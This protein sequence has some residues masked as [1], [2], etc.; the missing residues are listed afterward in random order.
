M[1]TKKLIAVVVT[2]LCFVCVLSLS[3]AASAEDL[4]EGIF[5]YTVANNKATLTKIDYKGLDE[6][7]IPEMLGGYEVTGLAAK[8]MEDEANL[9]GDDTVTAV[10]IPK[11]VTNISSEAFYLADLGYIVV[12]EDNP[13]YSSDDNGVLFNKDKTK[14]LNACICFSGGTYT[15]P[16]G[17]TSIYYRA[18]VH[19][20]FVK[21]IVLPDTV[22][23]I[24]SQAFFDC[25]S[26]ESVNVPEGVTTIY[27]MC[28]AACPS[29]KDVSLPSTLT[30]IKESAFTECY[31][32]E[33]IVIPE[34]VTFLGTYAFENDTS[35]KYVYLPSTLTEIQSG[36]LGNIPAT[37]ICYGGSEEDW[38]KISID[39][40]IYYEGRP[41][42]IDTA[43]IHYN[44]V[45]EAYQ[46][47][48]FESQND[49]LSVYGTGATPSSGETQFHYWDKFSQD[50][51][52][53]IITGQISKIGAHSFENFASLAT[54]IIETNNI[55][56]EPAAFVNCP[57]LENIIIFGNSSFESESF[58]ACAD[59][60]RVYENS[61][62]THDFSLSGTAINVVP[63]TYDGHVLSFANSVKLSSYEFFDTLAAFCLEYDNIEKV[64]FENLT[65]EDIEMYYIPEGG[66]SLKTLDGNTLKNGEIYPTTSTSA[67]GAITFN[68]LVNGM[69]D[70][71]ITHFY[72]IATDE[73]HS[74]IN[75]TEVKIS[76]TVREIMGRALRWIVTLLNKLFTLISRLRK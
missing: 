42:V 71:S 22:T 27:G 21:N 17:V 2:L 18:F 73:N 14:L 15:V 57:K 46:S 35:L 26:L 68:K 50:A 69:S 47:L 9:Y 24:G 40:Q 44:I 29:L 25:Q 13:N 6:I 31:S 62:A 66:A 1:K 74:N 8:I 23:S 37:D 41:V 70:G 76:D 72:L 43:T 30:E 16:D 59:R 34:G 51:T 52:T 39:T 58:T 61:S 56:I 63:Y 54:V 45:P 65:F 7:H 10:F 75:K 49:I 60:M 11:T 5:T 32:L 55:I 20:L 64:R 12:D 28:F 33:K 67:A 48:D 53:L 19:C 4:T 36:A 38:S 3:F